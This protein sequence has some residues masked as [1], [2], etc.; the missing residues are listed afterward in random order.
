MM[1]RSWLVIKFLKLCAHENDNLLCPTEM[2]LNH[3]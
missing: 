3:F 2:L 1:T